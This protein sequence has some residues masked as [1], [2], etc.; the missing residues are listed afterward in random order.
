MPYYLCEGGVIN[1][2]GSGLLDIRFG[3]EK[4]C[5]DYF[6]QCCKISDIIP[7]EKRPNGTDKYIDTDTPPHTGGPVTE[8]TV[9]G[10]PITENPNKGPPPLH[11]APHNGCGFRNAQG[12][13]FS[14]KGNSD[15]ESEYGKI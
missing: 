3:E 8:H 1:T 7:P 15:F 5:L 11:P 12:V 2:D 14:I 4:E 10:S 9:T 13:G 6:E